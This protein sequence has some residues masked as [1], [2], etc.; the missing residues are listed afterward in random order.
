MMPTSTPARST[1]PVRPSRFE[2]ISTIVSLK[3]VSSC[4]SGSSAPRCMSVAD[5][6]QLAAERARGV[7]GREVLGTE[8]A[9]LQQCD[10]ERVARAPGSR[11]CWRSARGRAGHAS[12]ATL[13]SST[14]SAA[15]ASVESGRPVIAMTGMPSR[16]TIGISSRISPVSPLFETASRRSLPLDHAEVAV[17]RFAGVQEERRRAGARRASRRSCGR[18]ARTCPC[19]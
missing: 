18:R 19:R 15:R 11:W 17:Q 3:G 14:T 2:V 10:S 5:P 6:H 9:M 4:T 8:A 16:F 1:T 12:S 13:T 7:Q